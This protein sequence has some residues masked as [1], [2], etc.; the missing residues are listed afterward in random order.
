LRA[1]PDVILMEWS[2]MEL[3]A[4]HLARRVGI[5]FAVMVALISFEI[6]P[7]VTAAVG[8]AVLLVILKCINIRQAA[9]AIDRQV[10]CLVGSSIALSAALEATNGSTYLAQTL[11][12]ALGEHAA[13]AVVLSAFFLLVAVLTNVLSNNATALLFTPVG[14][15]LAM[16]TGVEPIVFVGA[17]IYAANCSFAT[18]IG[19]QTNLLV[20]GPGHYKFIDFVRAGVPLMLLLWIVFSFVSPWYYGIP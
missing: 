6:V 14:I 19:Y 15:D 5:I 17:V 7:V 10:F 20:M 2:A 3:P 1:N 16:Q 8:A 4:P 18:P 11:V 12:A 9:R 13:P